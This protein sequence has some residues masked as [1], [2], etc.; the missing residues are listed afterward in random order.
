ME[1]A[2]RNPLAALLRSDRLKAVA[3]RPDVKT[4]QER[5]GYRF[6]D[7]M[8]L[9]E[10]LTH[11]SAAHG[12]K[13]LANYERLEFLGDRV[14]GLAVA[15][16]LYHAFPGA[17]EGDL[18]RRYNSL[19]RK[20]T[21]AEVAEEISLGSYLQLGESEAMAGGR[22]KSTILADSCEALLGAI[23]IDGGWDPVKRIIC[24]FWGPRAMEI[25]A[26]P[27]D[28]KTALQEWVQGQGE[29]R[30]PRYVKVESTGPDH[31]PVFVY[32]V[33][34]EGRE[35]SR[36]TGASRRAAEQAA[37]AAMLVREGV[38]DSE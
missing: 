25:E 11:A 6:R 12:R 26:V 35:P 36:G 33:R 31:A 10:A 17:P 9:H 28:A 29:T 7:N 19:V 16:H 37:A 23:Y 20:E 5:I 21:C 13:G 4:L 34:V 3:R 22:R 32:E 38:W 30:L 24:A 18:A 2:A 27:M 8:I 14:L 15:E 1:M